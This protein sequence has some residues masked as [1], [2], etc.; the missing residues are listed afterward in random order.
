MRRIN[1]ALDKI[2]TSRKGD[3]LI[4]NLEM[5]IDLDNICGL[6]WFNLGIVRSKSG[7]NAE[8]AFCFILCALVQVWD[9]EAWVN[10]TTCSFNQGVTHICPLVISTA[11]FFN[12]EDYLSALY[13]GLGDKFDDDVMGRLADLVEE[14]LIGIRDGHEA[15]TIRILHK[16]GV[17]REVFTEV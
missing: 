16:D 11:Y 17:F 10:A 13:K 3:A 8:A 15:P 1:E 4:R 6:A 7:D 9:I 14:L 12:G 2:D 5:A